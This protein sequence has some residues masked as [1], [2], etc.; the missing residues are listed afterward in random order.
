M[1]DEEY[2]FR[3]SILEKRGMVSG[4]KHVKGKTKRN[5]KPKDM[6]ENKY[7][8][9]CGNVV[10]FNLNSP[11]N[12]ATFDT[13]PNDL[14][15]EYLEKL[16]SLNL[17]NALIGKMFG[18]SPETARHILEK[19]NLRNNTKSGR[20]SKEIENKWKEFFSRNPEFSH[21]MDN[22]GEKKNDSDSNYEKNDDVIHD[23]NKSIYVSTNIK[24]S[25]NGINYK[26]EDIIHQ[27]QQVKDIISL[28]DNIIIEI[29]N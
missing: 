2:L 6:G 16:L 23:D 13:L 25:R 26:F 9:I 27:L 12:K 22:F 4:A 28:S 7:N 29:I 21:I 17:S 15:K 14:K 8:K 3:Q 11:I 19:N 10:Q 24:I 5:G 18:C 1:T 20:K